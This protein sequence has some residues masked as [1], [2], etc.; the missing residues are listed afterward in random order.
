MTDHSDEERQAFDAGRDVQAQAIKAL[1]KAIDAQGIATTAELVVLRKG[2][3]AIFDQLDGLAKP[4]DYS[5]DLGKMVKTLAEV[6]QGLNGIEASPLLK[7]GPTAYADQLKKVAHDAAQ[8]V[9]VDIRQSSDAYRQNNQSLA[10]LVGKLRDRQEQAW[11]MLAM[12]AVGI[13]L[14]LFILVSVPR[15]LPIAMSSRIAAFIA[16]KGTWEAGAEMMRAADPASWHDMEVGAQIMHDNAQTIN[17]CRKAAEKS[18]K[19]QRCVVII[20]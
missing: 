16:D 9:V 5:T 6:T 19:V 14:S 7:N 17:K 8:T 11:A 15:F 20:R 2:I 4:I 18:G 3:E 13:T 10:H 1:T 12:F